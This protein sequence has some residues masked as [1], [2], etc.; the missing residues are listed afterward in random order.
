MDPVRWRN[1]TR[2]RLAYQAGSPD[3]GDAPI[4]AFFEVSARCNLRCTMCAINYDTRYRSSSGRP[5]Y[6]TPDLFARLRPIFPSLHRAFLFGLGE[7]LLNPHLVDYI[8][9][10]SDHGVEVAFT[11]N[12]TLIDEEKADEIARA[13]VSRVTVS[14]D[15]ARAE[16]YDAIRV[17]ATFDRVMRGI[18]ALA[19][20]GRRYGTHT[21]SFS[22]VAMKSNLDDIPLLV[23]LCAEVGATGVHVEPLLAQVGK[24]ELDEHYERENLGLVDA[25][26][27]RETFDA[28]AERAVS[29]GVRFSSLFTSVRDHFDYVKRV[30]S[31]NDGWLCGA[32]WSMIWVTSAGEVRTCCLNDTSFGNLY[33]QTFDEI[34][35]G[36]F[37]RCFREQ[38]ARHEIATGCSNCLK[39]GRVQGS[40][41]LF[42]TQPVTNRPYFDQLPAASPSDDVILHWP[43][44]GATV[45]QPLHIE[46]I[47]RNGV[48]PLEIDVMIDRTPLANLNDTGL[49]AGDEFVLEVPVGSLTEGA[50]VLWMRD[51]NGRAFAHRELHFWRPGANEENH[52]FNQATVV[53]PFSARTPRLRA[54]GSHQAVTWR[55]MRGT[56]GAHWVTRVDLS[57]LED[58]PQELTVTA[59]SRALKTMHLQ[60]YSLPAEAGRE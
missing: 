51:A 60:K 39:N 48:D 57:S 46:G 54:G 26:V 47:L 2:N 41:F 34:W 45:G 27:V 56:R 6:L 32:P 38:H 25:A 19:E 23:D 55:L 5:P 31:L 40:E 37:Y 8:A 30:S 22:F 24:T 58:G 4:Q 17:G 35:N 13:G 20:A 14:I 3:A 28:A 33:E 50:H 49:F 15:G 52:V 29:H 9:E 36:A 43:V 12:A 59:G 18:R 11:T 21:V 53:A 10:L 42:P 1:I 16:T 7:P 44:H